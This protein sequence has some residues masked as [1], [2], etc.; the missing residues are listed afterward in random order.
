MGR[1]IVEF[2]ETP[3]APPSLVDRPARIAAND[4]AAN[5]TAANDE[6]VMRVHTGKFRNDPWDKL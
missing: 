2:L 4:I 3:V 6:V 5:D 1:G